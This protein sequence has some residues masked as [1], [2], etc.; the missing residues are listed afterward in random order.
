MF[1]G[2]KGGSKRSTTMVGDGWMD[3]AV[4]RIKGVVYNS[5]IVTG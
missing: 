3:E 2:V 1:G 5:V 4:D